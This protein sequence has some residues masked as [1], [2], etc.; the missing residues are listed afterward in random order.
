MQ[1][2]NPYITICS[3]RCEK[4]IVTAYCQISNIIHVASKRSYKPTCSRLPH[5]NQ[6]V[7]TS[8]DDHLASLV[9]NEAVHSHE[10]AHH[11]FGHGYPPVY[12]WSPR[13][14]SGAASGLPCFQKHNLIV[15]LCVA[16]QQLA[17]I[18]RFAAHTIQQQN[19]RSKSHPTIRGFAKHA[20]RWPAR[21]GIL[22]R[23][24]SICV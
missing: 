18:F 10:M 22:R 2:P 15:S 9:P 1:P 4:A 19:G 3:S 13:T 11:R 5:F 17:A 21:V 24:C 16:S 14:M 6:L 12:M 8:C 23:R 7:I 20:A